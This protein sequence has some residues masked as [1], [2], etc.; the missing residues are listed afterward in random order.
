MKKALLSLSIFILASCSI[1][2]EFK[3]TKRIEYLCG[4]QKAVLKSP[5][6]ERALLQIDGKKYVITQTIAASGAKYVNEE[7]KV[8]FWG[9]GN[10]ASLEIDNVIFPK[11]IEIKG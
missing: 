3:G 7:E 6:A 9:K 5:E 1:S 11:C 4:T 8:V 2:S 10:E